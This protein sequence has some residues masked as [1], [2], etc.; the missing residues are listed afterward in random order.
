M[1]HSPIRGIRVENPGLFETHSGQVD[2]D[3][4]PGRNMV[5]LQKVT[6]LHHLR[7]DRKEI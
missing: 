4:S 2:F 3:S 1:R 5:Y 7:R 6:G